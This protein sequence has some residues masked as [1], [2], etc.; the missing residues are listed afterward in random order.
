MASKFRQA[1][2]PMFAGTALML[3]GVPASAASL[4]LEVLVD[5]EMGGVY[6]SQAL[7]CQDIAGTPTA[8][9]V[10]SSPVWIGGSQGL[11]LDSWNLFVDSDPVINGIV[12]VT[13]LGAVTQQFTLLFTLPIA[14]PIP[15]GTLIGGSIQGGATDNN[16]NGVTLSSTGLGSAFYTARID[17]ADVQS[18]Y[19]NP[20]S[21]SA[22][23]F[24]SLSVPA[25]AF[26]TPIPSQAGPA[27]L[28]N[29]GIRLDF[30]LTPGDS[31]S[32]TSNFVVQPQVIPLP[33]ALLL[34]GGALSALGFVR[35]RGASCGQ[36]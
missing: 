33:P 30:L 21:F 17:G 14:P 25:L 6:D 9:C 32:F 28:T 3:S 15:G 22:G 36:A 27:A 7:G 13:N 2:I 29:I 23:S 18:L 31:A 24:L 4:G 20:Q 16:G 35:R 12:A 10:G 19:L 34:F 1:L 5:G 11:R 26:G 8:T